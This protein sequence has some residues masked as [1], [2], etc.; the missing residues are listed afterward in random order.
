M[1][2]GPVIGL[3]VI[4]STRP[5]LGFHPGPGLSADAFM[6]GRIADDTAFP[7]LLPPRLELRLDQRDELRAGLRQLQRR[8]EHLRERDEAR[9]ADDDVDRLR[10]LLGCEIAGV[11]LLQ[12]DHARVLPQLPRELVGADIHRIDLRR[13]AREQHIGE[14]AGRAADVERDRAAHI[15]AEVVEPMTPA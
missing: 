14:P 9:V 15:E 11:G 12:H 13:P 6:D 1:P 10:H 2:S 7:D 3:G 5:A 4:P 8:F